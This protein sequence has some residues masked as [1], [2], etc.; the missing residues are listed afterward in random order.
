[1]NYKPRSF[2][3]NQVGALLNKQNSFELN[4]N[5]NTNAWWELIH[6]IAL[7]TEILISKLVISFILCGNEKK[8]IGILSVGLN[9]SYLTPRDEYM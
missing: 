6:K 9:T 8:I 1:M 4:R 7:K 5:N 2:S 3:A